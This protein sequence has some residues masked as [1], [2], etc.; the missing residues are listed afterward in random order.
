[1]LRVLIKILSH[2]SAKKKTKRFKD[3]KFHILLLVVYTDIMAVKGLNLL[4][5]TLESG[6]SAFFRV[7]RGDI[8]ANLLFQVNI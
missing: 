6:F 1:M 2:A 3:F 7:L 8:T 4:L 5:S